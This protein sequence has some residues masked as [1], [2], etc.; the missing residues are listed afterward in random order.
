MAMPTIPIKRIIR[1]D[2][3]ST[4][5]VALA[6]LPLLL[7]F[8]ISHA[9]ISVVSNR[10][11]GNWLDAIRPWAERIY[12]NLE[13]HPND[14]TPRLIRRCGFEIHLFLAALAIPNGKRNPNFGSV[15]TVQ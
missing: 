13:S 7:Y 9:R 4:S 8:K 15:G 5:L 11:L 10:V 1:R 2:C 6:R 12:R 3:I 14:A